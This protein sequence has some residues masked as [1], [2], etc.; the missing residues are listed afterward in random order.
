MRWLTRESYSVGW[1]ELGHCT[2]DDH[3]SVNIKEVGSGKDPEG[4][5]RQPPRRLAQTVLRSTSLQQHTPIL[6]TESLW[7]EK[8][9]GSS[10]EE[11]AGGVAGS[12]TSTAV[13][14]VPTEG[15]QLNLRSLCVYLFTKKNSDEIVRY[16]RYIPPW[17]SMIATNSAIETSRST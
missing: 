5:E 14:Y 10:P 6:N 3:A 9:E 8:A 12:A 17:N 4:E 16:P 1:P 7:W 13:R 11:T 15:G 2:G